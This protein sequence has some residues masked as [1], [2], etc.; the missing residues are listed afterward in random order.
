MEIPEYIFTSDRLGFRDWKQ[1]DVDVFAAINGDTEVM[2]YFESIMTTAQTQDFVNR[3]QTEFA[4]CRHCYFAVEI[5]ETKELIGCIGLGNKDFEADF[6][7]CVDV[8]WRIGKQFWGKGYGTE[9]AKRCLEY[10]FE[11]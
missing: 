5:L 1:S 11:Q 8:G 3:M 9:G 6:T 4:R 7:P 10:G 2:Q